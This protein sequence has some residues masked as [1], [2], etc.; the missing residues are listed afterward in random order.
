MNE[1]SRT[2]PRAMG[3]RPSARHPLVMALAL[4]LPGAAEAA[5]DPVGPD[6]TPATLEPQ[7]VFNADFIHS[8]ASDLDLSRFERG[9]VTLAG[10]YRP[11]IEVNGQPVPG[12]RDVVFRQVADSTSAQP[13]FNRDMLVSFGLDTEKLRVHG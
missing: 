9:N 6:P 11:Q 5:I 12:S 10:I 1:L 13:C 7:A 2:T 3:R 4:A 8:S